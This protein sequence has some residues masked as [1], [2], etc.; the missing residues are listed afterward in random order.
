MEACERTRRIAGAVDR[1]ANRSRPPGTVERALMGRSPQREGEVGQQGRGDYG[2]PVLLE[3]VCGGWAGVRCGACA[4]GWVDLSLS[5]LVEKYVSARRVMCAGGAQPSVCLLHLWPCIA[6]CLRA[7]PP[8][9][10]SS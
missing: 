10:M 8:E 4:G 7:W 2:A 5:F 6:W 1:D 3:E 9:S